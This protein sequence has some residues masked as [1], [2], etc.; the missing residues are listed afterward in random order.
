MLKR[1]SHFVA[2]LLLVLL[3]LQGFAA[4]NMTAC[5]SLMQVEK[6]AEQVQIMPC[7][8]HVANKAKPSENHENTCKST[9]AALCASLCAMTT[10]PSNIKPATMLAATQ[11]LSLADQ[12]YASI[13]QAKLQ[14]PPIFLS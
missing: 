14:R 5:N 1:F 6:N 10:L 9:C 7:H 13:T 11:V 3:P 12:T 8:E 2:Y 4:A